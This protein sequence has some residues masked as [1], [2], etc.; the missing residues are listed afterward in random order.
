[1]A[2]V[3]LATSPTNTSATET[4]YARPSASTNAYATYTEKPTTTY[5]TYMEKPTATYAR[6]VH[7]EAYNYVRD[8][9]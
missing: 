4:S 7:R 2:V 5:P 1:M 9:H 6:D 8:I 3:A